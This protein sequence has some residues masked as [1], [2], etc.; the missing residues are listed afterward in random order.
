MSNH[1]VARVGTGALHI[2]ERNNTHYETICG[3]RLTGPK[4]LTW[5]A[6]KSAT[7]VWKEWR[8]CPTCAELD[9]KWRRR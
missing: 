8:R 2:A 7:A 5:T 3:K 9:R 6:G 4:I 1:L